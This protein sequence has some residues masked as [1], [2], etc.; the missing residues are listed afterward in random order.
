M[1]ILYMVQRKSLFNHEEYEILIKRSITI[2]LYAHLELCVPSNE[3]HV[4]IRKV[5]YKSLRSDKMES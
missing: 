1:K 2:A 5:G 3:M 4:N